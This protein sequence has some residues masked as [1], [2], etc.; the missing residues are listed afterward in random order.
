[1][2][3][4]VIME[5]VKNIQKYA[6]KKSAYIRYIV[7]EPYIVGQTTGWY[8]SNCDREST[9]LIR[10]RETDEAWTLTIAD[11]RGNGNWYCVLQQDPKERPL[12]ELH[13]VTDRG[14]LYWKYA[15]RQRDGQNQLRKAYFIEHYGQDNGT[16]IIPTNSN[17]VEEFLSS[18][19]ELG[20]YRIAADVLDDS[21][22]YDVDD[23]AETTEGQEAIGKHKRRERDSK[24]VKKAKQHA[25]SKFGYL[26]CECCGFVFEEKYGTIGKGFI[27][28]HHVTKPISDMNIQGEPV[29]IKDLALV[30]S[31]C[32]KMLHRHEPWLERHQLKTLIQR[33]I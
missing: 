26:Q 31:N 11:W 6:R 19:I 20:E 14:R 15:P 30:C 33:N 13:R 2:E 17:Q 12:V 16:V 5:V 28:A 29:S 3:R 10:S 4:D 24:L 23:D 7:T 1:M 9:F 8:N 22:Y 25:L 32:H 21:A 27:E 18:V